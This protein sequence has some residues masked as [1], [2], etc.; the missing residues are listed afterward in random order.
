MSEHFCFIGNQELNGIVRGRSVPSARREAVLASGLP[1]VPANITIGALNTLPP[2]NP[3]GPI[4]EIRLVP[5]PEASITFTRDKTPA[6]DI[7]LCEFAQSDGSTW[8][9]CPR[10]AL[11]RAIA[12]LKETTGLAL[13]V[14]L[15]HEFT[16]TGLDTLDH[17][18]FSPSAGR[19]GAPLA[20][21]VLTILEEAGF[22]LDQFVAEY[23]PGQYEI[24][25]QP[26]DPLAAADRTVL[27][28][29]AIRG[30]ASDLG[31]HASFLPKPSQ[32]QVG[33]G[34]H[35][36]FSLWRGDENVTVDSEWLSGDAG[37]FLAGLLEAAAPLTLLSTT[38]PNSFARYKPQSW[39]GT[40]ICAGL[41]NRETMVRVVPRQQDATGAYPAASM[42][43]RTSDA[44]A[45]VYL[46]LTAL[47]R[48][49]LDGVK[50]GL[51]SPQSVDQ[52]PATLDPE[53]RSSMGLHHLPSSLDTL[54]VDSVSA[55]VDDWLGPELT[56]AY[57]SCRR[58]DARHAEEMDFD[59]MAQ[60]LNVVF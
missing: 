47:I 39:V 38:S 43:Y 21:R 30:A 20:E 60:K 16:V 24:A 31:L 2:D 1:W 57:L 12:D 44:T 28:L 42:E 4:G 41:R 49:G 22:T 51:A 7:V 9:C 23:G 50:A 11:K 36:H 6:Y 40:Y 26:T 37:A 56:A 8:T 52:D 19:V 29:E 14:A 46:M 17:I 48:A 54:L 10:T 3:F 55:R 13:K 15:E 32:K 45:N 27:T 18:A 25:G 34:V 58:N 59:A 33:N 53:T 35:V 5:I